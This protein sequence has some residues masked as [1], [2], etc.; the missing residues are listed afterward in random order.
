MV[1]GLRLRL[2]FKFI[3]YLLIV[4][5]VAMFVFI[6]PYNKF[7]TN[8]LSLLPQND[9][10]QMLKLYQKFENSKE[11][12]VAVR[13]EDISKIQS[14]ENFFLQYDFIH[15]KTAFYN[16]QSF[17]EYRKKYQFY[18]EKFDETNLNDIKRSIEKMY[19]NLVNSYFYNSFDSVD[20]LSL[21]IQ[22]EIPSGLNI[23]KGKLFLENFGYMS[24]FTFDE[25]IPI[26]KVYTIFTSQK[27]E[28]V[29][30]FSPSFYFVENAKVIKSEVNVLISFGVLLLTLLYA[31]FLKNIR[32]FLHTFLVLCTSSM[33]AQLVVTSMWSEI[34]IFVLVFGISISTIAVDY[35]FHHY[36]CGFYNAKR[37]FNKAVFLGF[38]STVSAFFILSFIDFPFISQLSIYTVVSLIYSY[39]IFSFV[40]PFLNLPCNINQREIHSLKLLKN[41]R[42]FIVLIG[43]LLFLSL[44][45]LSF[46]KNIKNLDYQNKHLQ[47]LELF[48]K[49]NLQVKDKQPF[50][51]QANNLDV[52]VEKATR[53]KSFY[54]QAFIPISFLLTK[55][56]FK[57]RQNLFQ[58]I[59]FD[60]IRKQMEDIGK[61][62]GFRE[63]TFL[64]AYPQELV[65]PSLPSYNINILRDFGFDIVYDEG[66]YYS[67]GFIEKT[68]NIKEIFLLDGSS[69]F[70]KSLEHIRF[71]LLLAGILIGIIVIGLIYHVSKENFFQALSYVLFPFAF[72]LFCISF[73]PVNILQ[74]FMLFIV[75][76]LC[77]DYSIY[78]S[79]KES[80]STQAILFSLFSTFAGFGI[81]VFSSI[82]TL[83][84]LGE[85]AVLGLIAVLILL[86]IGKR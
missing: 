48:F 72:I 25:D 53:I 19:D 47:N 17:Y 66:V 60:N 78:I 74:I 31:I 44:S 9:E 64:K 38:F 18:L 27:H 51:I 34:S 20:P 54:P 69:F 39:C 85:V 6:A 73:Y 10:M 1:I 21:F 16:S 49:E 65:Y 11:V 43:I 14:L 77:V 5:S 71:E 61:Q 2:S 26:E 76:A 13:G 58:R 45:K 41:Y 52:L 28:D 42:Y 50:I 84:Y 83:F 7:S 75:V 3:H 36:F 46:D 22:K 37:G 86:I 62:V 63:N 40:F 4:C 70:E 67:F 32:L 68:D 79:E 35:M 59:D 24:I 56:E 57:K 23:Q 15:L 55:E 29:K 8:L 81:L 33:L 80:G 82:G 30:I 12:F